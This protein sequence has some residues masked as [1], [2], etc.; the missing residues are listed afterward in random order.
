MISALDALN[1]WEETFARDDAAP[2]RQ[3]FTDDFVL[4]DSDGGRQSFDDVADWATTMDFHIS[5]FDII[6][7]DDQCCCGTHSATL[8]GQDHGTV[9]FF[10]LKSQG[11]I[12]LWKIQ[13]TPPFE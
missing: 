13:R 1:N 6:H 11:R 8:D 10:A 2:L 7:D 4:I 3:M 5:D 9:C 12:S